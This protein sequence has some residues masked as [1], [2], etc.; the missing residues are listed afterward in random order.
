MCWITR[1]Q[2]QGVRPSLCNDARTS[3]VQMPR[4]SNSEVN[5]IA[6]FVWRM[7]GIF[8]RDRDL[9][10]SS[11]RRAVFPGVVPIIV[12]AVVV[13]VALILGAVSVS[14]RAPNGNRDDVVAAEQKVHETQMRLDAAL[15]GGLSEVQ[16]VA[17][18]AVGKAVDWQ[19]DVTT[20]LGRRSELRSVY[21]VA[22]RDGS[23]LARAGNTPSRIAGGTRIEPPAGGFGLLQASTSGAEPIIL[24][25]ALSHDQSV[26]VVAEF[27][28]RK[29]NSL[30]MRFAGDSVVLGRTGKVILSSKGYRAFSMPGAETARLGG[31]ATSVP[32]ATILGSGDDAAVLA[33]ERVGGQGPVSDLLWVVVQ[34]TPVK[35]AIFSLPVSKRAALVAFGLIGLSTGAL[36]LWLYASTTVP[37]RKVIAWLELVVHDHG[38]ATPPL[39]PAPRRFDEVGALTSGLLYLVKR[40]P[41]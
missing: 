23:V 3:P 38:A 22:N 18:P 9:T 25:I 12:A 13:G 29:L 24:A 26:T 17:A 33:S 10:S 7:P 19:R 32:F 39:A 4:S 31:E 8:D 16:S 30:L 20:V 5:R 21:A 34:R 2:E 27:E 11:G 37:L 1:V 36:L 14:H 28:P 6:G 41:R 35:P 40:G 15:L